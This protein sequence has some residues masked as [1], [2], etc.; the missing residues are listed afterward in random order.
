MNVTSATDKSSS[1]GSPNPT[2]SNSVDYNTFLQ[3]LVAE[4]FADRGFGLPGNS[5]SRTFHSIFVHDF[6]LLH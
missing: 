3:L 1:T 2:A 6:T 4:R 5:F